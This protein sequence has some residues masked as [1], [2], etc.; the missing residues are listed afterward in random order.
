MAFG[1]LEFWW[2]YMSGIHASWIPL[3]ALEANR[4]GTFELFKTMASNGFLQN[5]T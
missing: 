1:H 5:V 4:P 2:R 3:E